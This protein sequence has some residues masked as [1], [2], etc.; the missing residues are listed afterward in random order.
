MLQDVVVSLK[1]VGTMFYI[2]DPYEHMYP[3]D[4][5]SVVCPWMHFF[6]DFISIVQFFVLINVNVFAHFSQSSSHQII[7][8]S[9]S[10][11]QIQVPDYVARV[12]HLF[13]V[14]IALEIVYL[15]WKCGKLD[16]HYSIADSTTSINAG[17]VQRIVLML[18]SGFQFT[19]YAWTYSKVGCCKHRK[20]RISHHMTRRSTSYPCL[21][22][23]CGAG[24]RH[25]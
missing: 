8:Y 25:S 15:R 20:T 22:T 1:N 2:V 13:I 23:A 3:G 5:I 18:F 7:T 21:G 17:S 9:M 16:A 10:T 6:F 14:F 4:D 12:S 24:L 19:V 11:S